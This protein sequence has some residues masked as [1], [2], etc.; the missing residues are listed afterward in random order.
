MRFEFKPG[1]GSKVNILPE[2]E[3]HSIARLEGRNGIGKTMAVRLL[4]LCT[5][6]QP[7]RTA[8]RKAWAQLKDD[9]GKVTI[10]ATELQGAKEIVWEVDSSRW[11]DEPTASCSL[12][13]TKKGEE[14]ICTKVTVDSKKADLARIQALLRVHRLAGDETLIDSIEAD[15]E[16]LYEAMKRE[17]ERAAARA[18]QV[19][20]VI[21]DLGEQLTAASPSTVKQASDADEKAQK[22]LEK[23]GKEL[24]KA[25]ARLDELRGLAGRLKKLAKLLEDYDDPDTTLEE[26]K[27]ELKETQKERV[28]VQAQREALNLNAENEA[29]KVEEIGQ[30]EAEIEEVRAERDKLRR[31][32]SKLSSKLGLIAVPAGRGEPSFKGPRRA[33]EHSLDELL[34]QQANIDAGPQVR[35]LGDRALELFAE[36]GVPQIQG[37]PVATLEDDTRLSPEQLGPAIERRQAEIDKEARPPQASRLDKQIADAEQALRDF[38]VLASALNRTKLRESKITKLRKKAKGLAEGLT[39][40]EGER[41]ADFERQAQTLEAEESALEEKRDRLLDRMR[42]DASGTSVKTA[43]KRLDRDLDAAKTGSDSIA[44]D[45]ETEEARVAELAESRRQAKLLAESATA[46][47]RAAEAERE[48]A[49][50]R[51]AASEHWE[52]LR[53]A[54][55]LPADSLTDKQNEKR[56]AA[57]LRRCSAAE[58]ELDDASTLVAD[59]ILAGVEAARFIAREDDA[60]ASDTSAKPGA[61][62]VLQMLEAQLG[63][64][65]FGDP[66]IA[67]VLF[68]GGELVQFN[69]VGKTVE[70]KPE[71][72]GPLERHLEA[73]SSGERAFAYTKARLERLR[74]MPETAN[75]FVALDE[76]GAFLERSRL[77]LLERHLAEN[78]IGKSVDQALI[79]LPLPRSRSEEKMPYVFE[80]YE[81]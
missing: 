12:L 34:E 76:F 5:G 24:E 74:A 68:D 81:R 64:R 73:F 23:T 37:H 14:G 33:T 22:Q 66:A 21:G 47:H 18:E 7:Y 25:Q 53:S 16:S 58:V 80:P 15:V 65:Y 4:Q 49:L 36:N 56:A 72:G 77:E 9:L 46:T 45:V 54:D 67:E 31:Q 27:R 69:L 79:V 30:L 78:V 48:Q 55:L 29:Q 63:S 71:K 8:D 17:R 51:M 28:D 1:K 43:R 62:S 39:G 32:A 50:A 38:E 3:S 11:P 35:A 57:L 13:S 2:I 20:E 10:R 42:A 60:K 26:V 61:L 40:T 44:A 75:R 19:S 6:D 70:W 52:P 41:F 59:R